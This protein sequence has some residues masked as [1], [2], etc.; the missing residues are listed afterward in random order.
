MSRTSEILRAPRLGFNARPSAFENHHL[1]LLA[2]MCVPE[3]PAVMRE[4]VRQQEIVRLAAKGLP[5]SFVD[6]H[7][8]PGGR[9][10]PTRRGGEG[11]VFGSGRGEKGTETAKGALHKAM[12][13]QKT[14]M[15]RL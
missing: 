11:C 4:Q 1:D 8:R 2:A 15:V 9:G 14:V 5:A 10:L 13:Q 7:G 6:H 12:V 3:D